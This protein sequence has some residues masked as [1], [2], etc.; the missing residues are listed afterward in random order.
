M[1]SKE[2]ANRL[3][4][5]RKSRELT[6]KQMSELLHVSESSIAMCERAE[7]GLKDVK[8]VELANF[9]NV[10]TDYILCNEPKSRKEQKQRQDLFAKAKPEAN[11][12]SIT[13]EVMNTLDELLRDNEDEIIY[14]VLEKMNSK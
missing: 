1:P 3:T 10:S 2:I 6:Q 11:V 13:K 8:I 12:K 14:R 5:L 7:R 9:F 4:K